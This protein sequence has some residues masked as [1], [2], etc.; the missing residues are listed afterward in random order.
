MAARNLNRCIE[1]DTALNRRHLNSLQG[2]YPDNTA[3]RSVLAH[4]PWE[5]IMKHIV[6]K[7]LSENS[8]GA[9]F[10]YYTQY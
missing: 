10:N 6:L 4:S 8:I 1:G 7:Q 5:E 2:L 9:S 3:V